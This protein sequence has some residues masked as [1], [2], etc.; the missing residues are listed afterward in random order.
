[1]LPPLVNI[2]PLSANNNYFRVATLLTGRTDIALVTFFFP[3][4]STKTHHKHCDHEISVSHSCTSFTVLSTAAP[5][6]LAAPAHDF[7]LFWSRLC[8]PPPSAVPSGRGTRGRVMMQEA[9]EADAH[10]ASHRLVSSPPAQRP[11]PPASCRAG[12]ISR[13][14]PVEASRPG[15]QQKEEE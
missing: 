10:P 13:L 12:K 4:H 9:E 14:H 3:L 1:M 7:Q 15:R 5:A 8:L 11:P 2:Q 6:P